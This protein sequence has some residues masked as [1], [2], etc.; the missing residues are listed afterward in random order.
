MNYSNLGYNESTSVDVRNYFIDDTDI[1][2]VRSTIH[3][4]IIL[5]QQYRMVLYLTTLLIIEGESF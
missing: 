5:A 1:V 4:L 3:K 2:L